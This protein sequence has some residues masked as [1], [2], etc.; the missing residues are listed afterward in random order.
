MTPE[1][2]MLPIGIRNAGGRA[3]FIVK[4]AD[5]CVLFEIYLAEVNSEE[6]SGLE[7][8]AVVSCNSESG[9]IWGLSTAYNGPRGQYPYSR[10]MLL[11]RNSQLKLRAERSQDWE[12]QRPKTECLKME[13]G[14]LAFSDHSKGQK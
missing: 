14:C 1:L 9:K 5:R 2:L 6:R 13:G 10:G 7:I 4:I 3:S 11:G 8:E 12:S